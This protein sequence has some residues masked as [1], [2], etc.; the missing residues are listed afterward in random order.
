MS[1][2]SM[3]FRWHRRQRRIAVSR[4]SLVGWRSRRDQGPADFSAKSD[5]V[6][7]RTVSGSLM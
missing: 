3:V 4:L 2:R 5:A 1:G 7:V 6:R